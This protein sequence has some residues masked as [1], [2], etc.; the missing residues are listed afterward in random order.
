MLRGFIQNEDFDSCSSLRSVICSGESL[1]FDLQEDFFSKFDAQLHNLYGPTEASIDVTSWACDPQS[2][3]KIVPIGRPISNT[4]IYILDR[5]QQVVP[6]GISGEIYIGGEGL[7]RGYL[8]RPDLTADHFIPHPFSEE[9]GA[10]LY[11]TGDIGRY[12]NDGEIEYLGRADQQV[13]VRGYRIELGEV[14]AVLSEHP[15]VK[16]AVVMVRE[17]VPGDK[18]LAAYLVMESGEPVKIDDLRRYL[19]E[20]LPEY[21]I[22]SALVTLEELP[23]TSNG[24]VD[25]AAL[26]APEQVERSIEVV[27][28][29]TPVEELLVNLYAEVLHVERVSIEDNF[30]DLGGHSLLATQLVSRIREVFQLEVPLRALFDYPTVAELSAVLEGTIIKE[31]ESLSDEEA[32]RML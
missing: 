25:R 3:L 20:R 28:P 5:H 9:P 23:L 24:K 26:P 10:R 4:Q 32:Q 30:F 16:T 7:A 21:M 18:R 14:E 31:V 1:P 2:N 29:R 12:L 15:S 27:G 8:N 11:R 6:V 19:R 17:D 22:P 13:K